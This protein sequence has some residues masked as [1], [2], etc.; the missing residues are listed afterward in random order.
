MVEYVYHFNLQWLHCDIILSY[1]TGAAEGSWRQQCKAEL[2]GDLRSTGRR[3]HIECSQ[4][5]SQSTDFE[6]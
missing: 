2:D 3:E 6:A 5:I 4:S 1:T